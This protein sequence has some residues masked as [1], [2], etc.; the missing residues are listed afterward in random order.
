M[1]ESSSTK[2]DNLIDV[3]NMLFIERTENSNWSSESRA[4]YA[5][6]ELHFAPRACLFLDVLTSFANPL[7]SKDRSFL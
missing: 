5:Y 3:S 4:D 1:K 7:I 2:A 6:Q